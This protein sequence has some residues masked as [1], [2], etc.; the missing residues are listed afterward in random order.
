MKERP[1]CRHLRGPERLRNET[2]ITPLFLD[3]AALPVAAIPF[4]QAREELG[5]LREIVAV[6][7]VKLSE[8]TGSVPAKL[9]VE[10]QQ[11]AKNV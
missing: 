10:I 5:R 4:E 3:R 2:L 9:L 11:Q 8:A 1:H 6:I 7:L